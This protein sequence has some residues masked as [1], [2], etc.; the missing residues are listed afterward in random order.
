MS[1]E[2]EER[3]A[4]KIVSM[5]RVIADQMFELALE[6]VPKTENGSM[7]LTDFVFM[8]RTN[9]LQFIRALIEASEFK[10][11][12]FKDFLLKEGRWKEK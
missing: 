7:I 5:A 8:I 9:V 10:I 3:I 11:S 1:A 6:T 4:K 2:V 12:D